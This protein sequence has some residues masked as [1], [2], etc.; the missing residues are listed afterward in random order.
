MEKLS[1]ADPDVV[2]DIS[3]PFA[4][5]ETSEFTSKLMSKR[6]LEYKRNP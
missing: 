1:V 2:Y 4:D 3:G 5:L 6:A